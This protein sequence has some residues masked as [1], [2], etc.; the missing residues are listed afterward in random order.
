MTTG[1]QAHGEG[2]S[3]R[4]PRRVLAGAFTA[5]LI[6][7]AA[8][9]YRYGVAGVEPL[10]AAVSIPW[11]VFALAFTVTE[12]AVVHLQLRRSE[13]IFLLNEVPLVI[14][15]FF[16][17]P[18]GLVLARVLATAVGSFANPGPGL[19]KRTFN[20]AAAVVETSTAIVV[21]HALLGGAAP[22]SGA[23]RLD[24]L[25]AAVAGGVLGT[26]L[27][28]VVSWL[29]DGDFKPSAWARV[30]ATA[31]ISFS[32]NASLGLV[33]V[34]ILHIDRSALWFLL[35]VVAILFFAYRGYSTVQRRNAHLE[36]LHDFTRSVGGSLHVQSV[37]HELL[38]R[39]CD[40][41][42][43]EH[44]ELIV[45]PADGS[46]T[47]TRLRLEGPRID[48][49]VEA[50]ETRD[51]RLAVAAAGSCVLPRTTRDE[52]QRAFLDESGARD[53]VLVRLP[54]ESDLAATVMVADRAG[55]L[56]TFSPDDV[57]LLQTL[58]NHA[59][60]ALANGRLVDQLTEQAAA[61]EY[62]AL[63]DPLTGLANRTLFQRELATAIAAPGAKAAVL[64][65][66]LNSFKDVNDTLGHSVGDL[67][68]RDIG[69]RLQRALE[70]TGG[71]V[72]RLGGDE[73]AVLLPGIGG[74]LAAKT[75]AY[76]VLAVLEQHTT[77]DGLRVDTGA[78][79]GIALCPLHGT[80]AVTLL[81]RADI[82]MYAAK[83]SQGHVQLYTPERDY[84]SP[85][86]LALV[87]ELRSTVERGE[88]RV[89]YQPKAD[90]R[91]GRVV[92]AEA[93]ARWNHPDRG[94]IPPD[95]FIAVAERSGIIRE[96]TMHVLRTALKQCRAWRLAGHQLTVSVNLSAHSLRAD[97]PAQVAQILAE[98]GV[99]AA[100]LTLELTESSIM[101]DPEHTGQVL[102]Q[103]S[104]M[105]VNLAIDDFGTGYSSLTYLKRLPVDEIKIDKSFV[106][107]MGRDED[108]LAIVRSTVDLG[109]NLGLRV[110]A[111]GIEDRDTWSTLKTLGCDLAQG[112]YLSTP[113][114]PQE[115]DEWLK[116]RDAA[117]GPG[118]R[119][120]DI[121]LPPADA[122]D[123]QQ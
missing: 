24:A 50:P 89:V 1:L 117:G 78:S 121:V 109:R 38:V 76:E 35:V 20:V 13:H 33:A 44:A 32:A 15:L 16:T 118:V 88:L 54:D 10:R 102:D 82:A 104:A 14:G 95:E 17:G 80:E 58:A 87:G 101:A 72:A 122:P 86:R 116:A 3:A 94:F 83:E 73:F 113:A 37:A 12:V 49:V 90:L 110:V 30:L 6:V 99:A 85:Q 114:T 19:L 59:S 107:N 48:A 2:A 103:L 67:L 91:T 74:E 79:I 40:M 11:W 41:L 5:V 36:M 56:F 27:L 29:H 8:L 31:V 39:A 66:D 43:A 62:E 46:G 55:D 98:T 51:A 21:F 45:E 26:L 70:S 68:L 42:R 92:G 93:L 18:A 4:P 63:H 64:L 9:L 61:R 115:F 120:T 23:A 34:T 84:H 119:P 25:A 100:A 111:E 60:V 22:T 123:W 112:Y 7:G 97:F 75:V 81:R 57:R 77:I 28:G 108:D 106:L 105:G 47:A 71:L 53:A 52:R 69:G 65:M 96:L